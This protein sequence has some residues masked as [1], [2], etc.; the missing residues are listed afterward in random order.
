MMKYLYLDGS[1]GI[2]GDMTVAA[3]LGLGA[4]REKLDAAIAGLGLEG[5]HVHVENSKSYSIAGFLLQ[6]MSMTTTQTTCILTKKGM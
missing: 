2:S 6:C 3:L 1:C 5:V 4:S